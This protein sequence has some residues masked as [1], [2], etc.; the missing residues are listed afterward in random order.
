MGLAKRIIPCL[1][2]DGG[3]VV[4]GVNSSRSVTRA[5]RWRWLAATTSRAP[6]RSP[7]STSRR[8]L[9]RP[10]DHGL[11]V[12]EE[13]AQPGVHPADGGRRHPRGGRRAP[14]LNAGADKVAINYGGGANPD[15]FARAA[16]RFGSPCIVV[17]IDAKRAWRSRASMPWRRGPGWEV[18]THGGRPTPAWTRS[19]GP[20][21][22]R[23]TAQARSC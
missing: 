18:F 13:V 10:R 20:A 6:T 16:E 5:I 7:F 1:D 19:H 23:R 12:V 22:W 8:Q 4:K 3:R 15:L 2:V 14:L 9:R 21:R 17:A 11:H